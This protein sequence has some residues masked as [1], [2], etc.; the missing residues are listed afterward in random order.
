MRGWAAFDRQV[1]GRP[2]LPGIDGLRALAVVAVMLFHLWPHALPGGFVGV[3]IFF[4]IS[5]Y[6]VTAA[7]VRDTSQPF[8]EF[9][10]SFYARRFR[11][12]VPALVVC[13]CVTVGFS[14]ALIPNA[15][16]SDSLRDTGLSAFFG[17]SNFTLVSTDDGYFATRTEYNP[18]THT[19]SL[20]VEE[21]FYLVFPLVL[22]GGL[23]WRSAALG[24]G[25]IRLVG[26]LCV[27]SLLWC[28]WASLH[29][30]SAAY[31]MLPSRF[32]E[33]GLGALLCLVGDEKRAS[34]L[35]RGGIHVWIGGGLFLVAVS[36]VWADPRAFPFPWALPAVLG[37]LMLVVAFS[38]P[39]PDSSLVRVFTARPT[40]V[41]GLLSYSLYLWHWPV[42]TLLRWTWGLAS[43]PMYAL[44]LFLTL[45]CAWCSYRW[46]E[47]P[48]QR[49]AM[50]RRFAP[51][52]IVGLGIGVL[53]VTWAISAQVYDRPWLFKQTVV[54]KHATDW[55]P[56]A[57]QNDPGIK[58]VCDF[59]ISAG[60]HNAQIF[61]PVRCTATVA[62]PSPRL[63]V[64]GDSHAGAYDRL[65]GQW[66]RLTGFQAVRYTKGGC[67]VVGLLKPQV[68]LGP[69]CLEYQTRLLE[70]LL[71][72]PALAL[73][74]G[75]VVFLASLRVPRL[76]DQY[77]A[78][79]QATIETSLHSQQALEERIQA[80]LEAEVLLRRFHLA[81]VSVIMDA[82]KPVFPAPPFRCAD[83]FNRM[84]PVCAPGHVVEKTQVLSHRLPVLEAMNRL[85]TRVPGVYV[86]DPLPVLCP[87]VNCQAFDGDKPL[88]FDGDHLSGHGNEV[89]LPSFLALFKTIRATSTLAVN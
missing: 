56:L 39:L 19:W 46:V 47:L 62:S 82:P 52:G 13:L 83:S 78:I 85:A 42:Y 70:H 87:A 40:V 53:L 74:P 26:G 72:D 88:F 5:G 76:S 43:W 77:G 59:E 4:V 38:H 28:A 81:G 9:I 31:Y 41:V 48:T 21:Q 49:H 64:L 8:G 66:V 6:V 27:L 55:Y 58:G 65:L 73:R 60:P 16:L 3:D 11:R 29:S 54:Q 24:Q 86:W 30:A 50:L 34:W 75:D 23:R 15:W 69:R 1:E 45:A 68:Q 84:N 7:M 89:L 22:Y 63:I 12:I 35:A 18:F 37:T 61:S 17:L 10:A 33:L 79:A 44:A 25:A 51:V 80:E 32:W 2:Y 71:G 57:R 20:A 67:P 36:L 14:V